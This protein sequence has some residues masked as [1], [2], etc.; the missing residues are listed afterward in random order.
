MQLFLRA[1][2][3]GEN[4]EAVKQYCRVLSPFLIYHR[5]LFVC[6]E[7]R[8]ESEAMFTR[9]MKQSVSWKQ[10]MKENY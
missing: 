1:R 5:I 3:L 9:E 2:V 8:L 10:R 7:K 6:R 4:D